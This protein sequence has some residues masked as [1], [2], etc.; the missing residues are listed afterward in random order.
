MSIMIKIFI[1]VIGFFFLYPYANAQ[2]VSRD[3]YLKVVDYFMC[4]CVEIAEKKEL[5]CDSQNRQ[6]INQVAQKNTKELIS[7]IER[8]RPNSDDVWNKS[9]LIAL[10]TDTVLHNRDVYPRIYAFAHKDLDREAVV[11]STLIQSVTD[12]VDKL[13]ALEVTVEIPL[14][15][16]PTVEVA[17]GR[18][19]IQHATMSRP[20]SKERDSSFF[21]FKLNIANLSLAVLILVICI[22]YVTNIRHGLN[23]QIANLE[24]RL[25]A[26]EKPFALLELEGKLRELRR[27]VNVLKKKQPTERNENHSGVAKEAPVI[28]TVEDDVEAKDNVSSTPPLKEVFYMPTPNQDGSF[29]SSSQTSHFKPTVSLYKFSIS[30]VDLSVSEFEFSSDEFG[31]KDAVNYPQTYLD[32]VCEAINAVNQHAKRIITVKKGIA[33]KEGDKWMVSP[34]NKARIRYE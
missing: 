22:L 5:D 9:Q 17:E 28:V 2:E 14:D 18:D 25:A 30:S 12:F 10:L 29:E 11:F 21:S 23:H 4:R 26:K 34:E 33:K 16:A 13:P 31:V 15:R 27:E 19:E 7:E 1:S 32:P 6:K 8:L 20:V 24:R 3:D